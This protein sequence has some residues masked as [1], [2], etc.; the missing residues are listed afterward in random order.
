MLIITLNFSDP[1]F[2]T[3][4]QINPHLVV[5]ALGWHN[6]EFPMAVEEASVWHC[7][8]TLKIGRDWAEWWCKKHKRL[9]QPITQ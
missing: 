2:Q 4:T 7:Q 3:F 8:R 1:N 9:E 6:L 5:A